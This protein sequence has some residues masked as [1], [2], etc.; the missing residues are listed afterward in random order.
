MEVQEK[1]HSLTGASSS[2]RWMNC[3]GSN[4]LITKLKLPKTSSDAADEGTAAHEVLSYCLTHGLD[5]WEKFGE[6]ILINGKAWTVNAEMVESVQLALDFVR[7]IE[8]F[9]IHVERSIQSQFQEDLYGTPDVI[10]QSKS[11]ILYVIDFKYGKGVVVEPD[12]TQ[13]K[14]YAALVLE[15]YNFRGQIA[16]C[17]IQPRCYHVDGPCRIYDTDSFTI[18]EWYYKELIPALKASQNP[19]AL[20]TIGDWCRFCPANENNACPAVANA[21]LMLNPELEPAYLTDEELSDF[22]KKAPAIRKFFNSLE[23][24][25]LRRFKNGGSIPEFKI[26]KRKA[27]RIWQDGAEKALIEAYGEKAYV[28]QLISPAAVEKLEGGKALAS[29]WAIKPDTGVTIA[30]ISDKRASVPLTNGKGDDMFDELM[31][32]GVTLS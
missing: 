13:L 22:M 17:I 8:T 30:K 29:E 4:N 9:E 18:T 5:A 12:S 14:Y 2:S 6:S 28:R 25:I 1:K 3:A 23:N 19:N 11:N 20:L 15:Q 10:I 31:D 32:I 16:L 27:D 21:A 24:E 7:D 26:V